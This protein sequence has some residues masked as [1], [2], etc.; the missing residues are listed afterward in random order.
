MQ[1]ATSAAM[2]TKPNHAPSVQSSKPHGSCHYSCL[3]ACSNASSA[4]C[5]AIKCG[6]TCKKTCCDRQLPPS[7]ALPTRAPAEASQTPTAARYP[8]AVVFEPE[9]TNAAFRVALLFGGRWFGSVGQ[10][11]VRNHV[12]HL[13]EPAKRAG[14]QIDVYAAVAQDGWCSADH[15]FSQQA[16]EDE[17]TAAF[18]GSGVRSVHA[19]AL[20]QRKVAFN[21]ISL[22]AQAN[23]AGQEQE[24]R[25][26]ISS[27]KRTIFI[28][29][30]EQYLKMTAAE[31]M[32][33]QALSGQPSTFHHDL[34]LR[35]RVDV[36]FDHAVDVA[37]LVGTMRTNPHQVFALSM[38]RDAAALQAR[39]YWS[40]WTWVTSEEVM[41]A[42]LA[43][44]NAVA[45]GGKPYVDEAVPFYG[46]SQ[47]AQTSLQFTRR[48]NATL[49]PL[50]WN[51]TKNRIDQ[52]T[53]VPGTPPLEDTD[54]YRAR[55]AAFNAAQR[56]LLKGTGPRSVFRGG[57]TSCWGVVQGS[58]SHRGV[59]A[60]WPPPE[61]TSPPPPPPPPPRSAPPPPCPVALASGF[62][63]SCPEFN[64]T[65]T[66]MAVR[67]G[68]GTAFKGW[69]QVVETACN[70]SK[71][72]PPLGQ[73]SPRCIT[74]CRC[75]LSNRDTANRTTTH[76]LQPSRG[77]QPRIDQAAPPPPP[78]GV[79]LSLEARQAVAAWKRSALRAAVAL[80][81]RPPRNISCH[82]SV[83]KSERLQQ[84]ELKR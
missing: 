72:A 45:Q 78:R 22:A 1:R 58:G 26:P 74:F 77:C 54:G 42:L 18:R 73:Y 25:V 63:G 24:P 32:R 2:A 39:A 38:H 68:K 36:T 13:V 82:Q 27:T 23:A 37:S 52:Q 40:D 8:S 69:S 79:A 70:E 50:L 4:T 51:I 61:W 41:G 14:G 11:Y 81:S 20:E 76:H 56:E 35:V 5:A 71:W 48:G 15:V 65:A 64:R 46:L 10:L 62:V 84:S 33:R 30:V 19:L 44:T 55:M 34:V 7:A 67:Y 31:A 17:M 3:S 49:R 60:T 43:G 57:N 47:E 28:K 83:G 6:A 75:L 29:W 21:R 53:M 9:D 80:G 59:N 16:L 66:Q 12:A